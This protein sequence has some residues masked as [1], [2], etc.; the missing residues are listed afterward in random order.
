[1]HSYQTAEACRRLYPDEKYDW[2][3]LYVDYNVSKGGNS[4]IMF[5]V[6]DSGD[7]TWQSGPEVQ[8]MD[9]DVDPHGQ[10]AGYLYQLYPMHDEAV[11]PPDSTKPPGQWNRIHMI[12]APK[13]CET[14]MNGVKYHEYVYGSPDF[15]TRVAKSKFSE[16]PGFGKQAIGSIAIQ[17]D[18][19]VVSF[20]NI[21]IRRIKA[22]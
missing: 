1:M 3:E 10:L 22:K 2:F 15:W 16:F 14:F 4:G 20:K 18:H 11:K 17:G 5:R 21:K 6:A 19:G 7:T 12:V 9:K 13:K 8:I